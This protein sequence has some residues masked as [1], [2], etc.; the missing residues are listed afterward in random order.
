M[1]FT[2]T[3]S[4]CKEEKP[5]EDFHKDTQKKD[6]LSSSCRICMA[7]VCT[8][9]R[10]KNK[11]KCYESRRWSYLKNKEYY[12]KMAKTYPSHTKQVINKEKQASRSL[13]RYHVS[14]GNIIKEPCAYCGSEKTEIH[15]WEY[16]KKH[17]IT[18]F[19]KRH[20]GLAHSLK[21]QLTGSR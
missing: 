4:K 13:T 17:D 20:H 15:H 3:C 12:K 1:G 21:H 11:A 6:G 14:V 2:K 19:C 10:N 7:K 9:Y 8:I 18:W 5:L 16:N